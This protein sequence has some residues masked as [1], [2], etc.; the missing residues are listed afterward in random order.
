LSSLIRS[1]W[2]GQGGTT[3]THHRCRSGRLVGLRSLTHPTKEMPCRITVVISFQEERIPSPSSSSPLAIV[4]TQS[5]Y[6]RLKRVSP[7]RGSERAVR[8]ERYPNHDERK[9]SEGFGSD[10]IGNTRSLTTTISRTALTTPTGIHAN[11]N[12]FREFATGTTRLFTSL[13]PEANATLIGA[14][15]IPVSVGTRPTNGASKVGLG[16]SM[17]P[18]LGRRT[19]FGFPIRMLVDSTIPIVRAAK[20]EAVFRSPT[21]SPFVSARKTGMAPIGFVITKMAAMSLKSSVSIFESVAEAY[22]VVM[23]RRNMPRE[24]TNNA[25]PIAATAANCCHTISSPASR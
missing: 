19:L 20:S 16:C 3:P 6:E 5:E 2:V 9:V 12:W 7:P 25:E 8:K 18:L 17:A 24:M 23:E 21:D 22:L 13:L 4:T 14:A 10:D 1:G 15:P 11:T